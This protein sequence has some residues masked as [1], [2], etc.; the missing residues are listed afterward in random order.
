LRNIVTDPNDAAIAKMMVALS[1]NMG[2]SVIAKGVVLQAQVD[3][4]ARLGC[5]TSF[6]GRSMGSVS[7][8]LPLIFNIYKSIC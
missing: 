1:E 8:L 2:I 6:V 3:L 7:I 4:L 5:H